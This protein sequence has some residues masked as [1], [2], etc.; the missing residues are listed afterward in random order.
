MTLQNS[1]RSP[2]TEKIDYKI[3]G[4]SVEAMDNGRLGR[5]PSPSRMYWTKNENRLLLA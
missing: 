1:S 4:L 5:I 3:L 2:A